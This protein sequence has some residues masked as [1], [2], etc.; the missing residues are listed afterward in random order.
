M[1]VEI[2]RGTNQR[3]VASDELVEVFSTQAELSG[4]L[5][6]GY[7]IIGTAEGP[8]VIDALLVSKD[9]GIA[10]ICLVEGPN[11]GG[12][13]LSQDDS[14]NKL[15]SKL[16]LHRNLVDRRKLLVPIHA[17]SFAPGVRQLN[18]YDS[19][20]Y[21]IAN[22][23]NLIERL[24]GYQ[25]EWGHP[26]LFDATL[27]VIENISTIRHTRSSR[28][29]SSEVSK[30]AKL[31]RLEDSIATLD[32]KQARA[33]IETVDGVQRIRG[34]AGSGKTVALA[35]KAAYL[36]AQHPDW[37]IAV[38]FNTR[39]LKGQFRRL[40]NN[41]YLEQANQEPNWENL[42][43]LSSWGAPGHDERNGM[44]YEFCRIHDVQYFDLRSA[45]G[46]RGGGG[47][48]TRVC[49]HAV[50]QVRK[51][52]P[53]YDAILV[54]EAQDFSPAF[55]RLCH[56]FLKEPKRLVYAY[57][58]LQN[59]T[60]E[61]LP[62]PEDIFE[63]GG[64]DFAEPD[65]AKVGQDGASSDIILDKCYRNSRP[66]LV[67]AHALGFGIYR[68]PPS[69]AETGLI[70]MFD[71]AQLW[72]EVGYQA[73]EGTLGEGQEVALQRTE[74]TSPKFLEDH[75]PIDDLIQFKCFENEEEQAKWLAQAI[76]SNL[77]SDELRHDDIVVIN[78]DPLTT[79]ARVGPARRLLWEMDINSHL[80]GVNTDPDVFFASDSASV[81]FSGVFR[82]KGNEAG[83]VYIINAQD[84]H[85]SALNLARIRNQLFT[86]MTRSKAW[87]RVLG[88]G[89]G[90]KEL[91][92]E[93]RELKKRDFKLRFTYPDAEQ[94]QKLR[95]V[96]RDMTSAGQK[97]W[98]GRRQELSRLV[99][100][101]ESGQLSVEDLDDSD[102][103][104]L[105][106]MLG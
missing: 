37:H 62:S 64:R 83:M 100:D 94:R 22:A 5:F 53:M 74:E 98:Q 25:G 3:P 95:M 23:G 76:H 12:F 30:G 44:Y 72:T 15:E 38:T 90:M 89:S 51:S 20:D 31:K 10:V 47:P 27:S 88:V 58:E 19:L 84:C 59:L 103:A 63:V 7:P 40:I 48:F 50:S 11:P 68:K 57:D 67:A 18:E 45:R 55:L 91:E 35:L 26:E 80:A 29:V 101:L 9:I 81:T 1:G 70:Q 60:E 82:A 96:H 99:K 61:S 46:L 34:L 42:R 41:S 16:K 69:G 33:V 8:F 32:N 85:S 24:E 92:K 86:A 79:R 17:V 39:S 102:V 73:A 43:I 14:V 75:S 77:A 28:V 66:V 52:K 36:H 6:V 4:Q 105:R 104:K 54:D 93:Y 97:R 106:E 21:P 87:I 71:N 78:P 2:V 65:S 49:E 13:Q 56:M